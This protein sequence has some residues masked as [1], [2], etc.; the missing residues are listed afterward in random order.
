MSESWAL[1]P[2]RRRNM[3]ANRSRDTKPERRLRSV[4]HRRGWRFRVAYRPLPHVR[5]SADVVFTKHRVAVFVDGCFWHACPLHFKP[6]ARNK[7]YW[8][9]KIARNRLRDNEF[10]HLLRE[11]GWT[12][13]RIWEHEDVETVVERVEKALVHNV[14]DPSGESD[15]A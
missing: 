5:W 15:N 8:Q 12:V 9:P 4:L 7:D 11:A 14:E 10:D 1:N 6:P 3:Q 2:G 13:V